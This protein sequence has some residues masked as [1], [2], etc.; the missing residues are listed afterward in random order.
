MEGKHLQSTFIKTKAYH[1]GTLE[2]TIPQNTLKYWKS[3]SVEPQPTEQLVDDTVAQQADITEQSD[4][5]DADSEGSNY[6]N[7]KLFPCPIEGCV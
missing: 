6:P 3:L 4:L 7:E 2:D 1:E 5:S